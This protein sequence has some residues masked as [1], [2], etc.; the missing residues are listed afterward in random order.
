MITAARCKELANHY[1]AISSNLDIS[2][3]R[4]F[5]LRNIAKSLTG[6]AGQL[7][8]LEALTRDEE[9]VK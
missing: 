8:R 3:S 7:D 4:A 9:T 2:E 6:L 1:K 5:V